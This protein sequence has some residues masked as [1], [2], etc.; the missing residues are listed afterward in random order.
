MSKYSSLWLLTIL[1]AGLFCQCDNSLQENLVDIPDSGFLEG[2]IAAGVDVNH[3]GLV[4]YHEA[5]ATPSIVIPPSGITDLTGLEAFVNLDSFSITLNPLS[6]IDLS[7]NKLLRYLEVTSC[8]LSSLNLSENIALEVL[9]CGRNLMEELDVSHNLSLVTLVCNNNLFTSLDLA[10]NTTLTKMISCGNQLSSIDLSKNTA[11][12][13][14]GIDNMPMLID[15]CVWTL[16][17]PPPGV[18]MLMGFS[19]NIVFTDQCAGF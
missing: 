10:V 1:L 9:I 15:V 19:P 16:P 12:V 17:F 7:S 8:E 18:D 2:L 6:G 13:K 4:S 11:L 3:D 5:E 14:I